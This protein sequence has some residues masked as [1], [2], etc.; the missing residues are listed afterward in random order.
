MDD[1]TQLIL[2]LDN[3]HPAENSLIFFFNLSY[4]ILATEQNWTSMLIFYKAYMINEDP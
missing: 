4:K 2:I 1:I 3:A